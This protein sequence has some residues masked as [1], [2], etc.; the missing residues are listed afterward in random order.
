MENPISE[1]L[2]ILTAKNFINKLLLPLENHYYHNYNH[3]LDVMQRAVYLG[4]KEWLNEDE[5][6]IIALAS[7][8]HDTWFVIKYDKNEYIWAKIARN[9]L[10]SILYPENKIEQIEQIILATDP[11]YKE[12]KNIYEKIIKDSDLDNL[13]WEDFFEKWKK[14]K[15][16]LEMIK[17][18]KI[19]DSTWKHWSL[20]LLNEH[21]FFTETAKREKE[22]IKKLNWYKLSVL[23]ENNT[24]IENESIQLRNIL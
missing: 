24:A 12:P 13:W 1:N 3:A 22:E 18:I 11:D 21:K 4:I 14:L 19:K 9:Y 20:V 23:L 10:K 5:L 7:I 17:N 8:F 15:K 6:E 2:K 16:E